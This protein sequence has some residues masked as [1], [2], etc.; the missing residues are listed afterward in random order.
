MFVLVVCFVGW[1]SD[2]TWV[3]FPCS[4]QLLFISPLS[5]QYLAPGVCCLCLFRFSLLP[6]LCGHPFHYHQAVHPSFQSCLN[7]VPSNRPGIGQ[8][9]LCFFLWDAAAILVRVFV[10]HFVLWASVMRC[11]GCDCVFPLS[12]SVSPPLHRCETPD[13]QYGS[14]RTARVAGGAVSVGV[15]VP[16]VGVSV[17][18]GVGVASP[19]GS[20]AARVGVP[21]GGGG[22]LGSG[23]ADGT[24]SVTAAEVAE[25][26]LFLTPSVFATTSSS[27][28]SLILHSQLRFVLFCCCWVLLFVLVCLFCV[29]FFVCFVVVLSFLYCRAPFVVGEVRAPVAASGAPALSD[30][31][32]RSIGPVFA[33]ISSPRR[34]LILHTQRRFVLLLL[35]C[36]V[37][38]CLLCV[39]CCC[40]FCCCSVVLVLQGSCR[41]GRSAGAC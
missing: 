34:R 22:L 14:K 16:G 40:L 10:G 1:I 41:C 13:C 28:C 8:L 15:G 24:G 33:M 26:S 36:F 37:C 30:A 23:G 11:R 20:G 19:V 3:S 38:G 6:P 21:V 27:R 29:Y 18:G 12:T 31:H 5:L 9:F 4:L 25:L 39:L 17:V 7:C 35:G 2:C 32:L